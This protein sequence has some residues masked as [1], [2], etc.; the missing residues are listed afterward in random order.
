VRA[1]AVKRLNPVFS[2]ILGV[3]VLGES[4]DRSTAIGMLLIFLSFG[5][6]VRQS[7]KA[8]GA[9]GAPPDAQESWKSRLKSLGFFYGPVSA[10]AYAV[11]YIARKQGLDLTPD[12]ALGTMVGS[13]VGAMVF[14]IAARF[15]DSYRQSLRATF[16]SFNP[17]LLA[18]GILSSVGQL[19][20]FAALSHTTIS[21]VALMSSMEVFLTIFF[22]VIILRKTEQ[23]SAATLQAACLGV[24]GTLFIVLH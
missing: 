14:V 10:L 13:M 12:A 2:V 16:T 17:W 19:L 3:L 5:V 15:V 24:A 20:Y 8:A 9:G 22:S 6:L 4:I 1:S 11:G 18:A 21:R 7:L 23:L